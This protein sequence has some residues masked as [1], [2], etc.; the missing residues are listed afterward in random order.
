MTTTRRRWLQLLLLISA[1]RVNSQSTTDDGGTCSSDELPS[2]LQSEVDRILN[3]Q[4]RL[5]QQY[6]TIIERLGKFFLQPDFNMLYL[7]DRYIR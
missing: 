7:A 1:Q 3:N 6:Q 4:Q 2:H 5:F